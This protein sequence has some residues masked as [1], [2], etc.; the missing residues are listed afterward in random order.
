MQIFRLDI[1][2][3]SLSKNLMLN[4]ICVYLVRAAR[5]NFTKNKDE[6]DNAVETV[7]V[8]MKSGMNF[9]KP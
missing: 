9:L 7:V 5:L 2:R 8:V 4:F 1:P 6:K 3:N